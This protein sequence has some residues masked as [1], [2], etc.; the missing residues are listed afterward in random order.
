MEESQAQMK[1]HPVRK[2]FFWAAVILMAASALVYAAH[3]VAQFITHVNILHLQLIA[4]LLVSAA[5]LVLFLGMT[6]PGRLFAGQAKPLEGHDQSPVAEPEKP[7]ASPLVE[8]EKP[9]ASPAVVTEEPLVSSLV[10]KETPLPLPVVEPGK[11]KRRSFDGRIRYYLVIAI[12]C[13]VYL[14]LGFSP[15]YYYQLPFSLF[16]GLPAGFWVIYKLSQE[17]KPGE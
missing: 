4:F 17:E 9:A 13:V 5:F 11:P 15:W 6:L 12:L 7:T 8:P 14:G 3:L 10:E 1:L 16:V 2:I